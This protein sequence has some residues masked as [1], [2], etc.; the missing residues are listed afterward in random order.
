MEELQIVTQW[1][2]QE[3]LFGIFRR[4]LTN[5]MYNNNKAVGDGAGPTHDTVSPSSC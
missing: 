4:L 1:N 3:D 2:F 5:Q